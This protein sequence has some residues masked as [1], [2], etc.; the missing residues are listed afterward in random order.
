MAAADPLLTKDAINIGG[1]KLPLPVVG[2]AVG[3]LGLVLIL[4]ARQQSS[5]VASVGAAPAIPDLSSSLA[6][7][8]S[9]QIA[10]LS[11]QIA[12]LQAPAAASTVA[13]WW[14]QIRGNVDP[15][16]GQAFGG[17]QP[18][19]PPLFSAPG[20]AIGTTVPEGSQLQVIG[21]P[22]TGPYGA[23]GSRQYFPVAGPGGTTDY[24]LAQDIAGLTQH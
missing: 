4:R 12:S 2:A 19:N 9:Q 6:Q 20:V 11:N 5:S 17:S 15:E 7:D 24:I 21:A 14:A 13:S 3:V 16:T 8:Q 22:I 10:D 23:G 1:H 18:V